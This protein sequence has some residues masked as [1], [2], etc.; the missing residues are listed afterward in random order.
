MK[1][2]GGR[3]E[4]ITTMSENNPS[5]PSLRAQIFLIVQTVAPHP[6]STLSIDTSQP[7]TATP[8]NAIQPSKARIERTAH[9][10]KAMIPQLVI[11]RKNRTVTNMHTLYILQL[12]SQSQCTPHTP[13]ILLEPHA[14][15]NKST[16]TTTT[17]TAA[18]VVTL[19]YLLLL[20]VRE[21]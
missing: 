17:T 20:R 21:E 16:A 19:L 14:T 8:S 18:N 9:G 6:S 13:I 15:A 7:S 4:A 1:R 10:R 12:Q 11:C 3:K 5:L 2:E